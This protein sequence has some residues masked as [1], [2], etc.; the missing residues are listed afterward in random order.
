MEIPS[1]GGT[2]PLA[3]LTFGPCNSLTDTL[4]FTCHFLSVSITISK[5]L[6]WIPIFTVDNFQLFQRQINI[7]D[8]PCWRRCSHFWFQ[9]TLDSS[10]NNH[11]HLAWR[12]ALV[13][14]N[15]P[16]QLTSYDVIF[17]S[18]PECHLSLLWCGDRLLKC[19]WYLLY[20]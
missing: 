20:T 5:T 9:Y 16:W 8:N 14:S 17:H 12:Y 10:G 15:H 18:P 11:I 2:T 6:N 7:L 4:P 3:P 1:G 13:S 19:Y